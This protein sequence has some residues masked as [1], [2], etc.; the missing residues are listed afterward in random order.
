MP[1]PPV[2]ELPRT[3]E[4]RLS[5]GHAWIYR[6]HVPPGVSAPSGTWFRVRA[7]RFNG[8]GLWDASS[9]IA[10][11]I[12]SRKCVPDS[13]WI[14]GKVKAAHEL[15][16]GLRARGV[17]GYRWINGEG[18]GLPGLVVDCYGAF[19]VVATYADSVEAL[20]PGVVAA[21][22]DVR[23]PHGVV[24]LCTNA[25]A[26]SDR[27]ERLEL[28][29]GRMPPERLV[30]EEY[31][32]RLLAELRVAQK[33]GLYLDQRE[34]RH[35]LGAE[36]G[37]VRVLNLFCYTGAFSLHALRGGAASVVQVDASERA[38]AAARENF[39][40]NGVAAPEHEFVC[41][42]AFEYLKSAAG[43]G[44]RFDCVIVDPPSFARSRSQRNEA[45]HAY[46]RLFAL[47]IRVTE[48]GGVLAASSCTAQVTPAEF[49]TVLGESAARVRR[50]LQTFHEA[51]HALDHPILAGHP[52]GRYLKFVMSRVLPYD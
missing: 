14:L 21:L 47:A 41:E 11:R 37:G 17:S 43:L 4:S 13:A 25:A 15:R 29:F 18:D 36:A 3:L 48:P 2:I 28:L 30:V 32:V 6:D 52:E 51:G 1:E 46:R 16:A 22:A 7:G 39:A 27:G 34:N 45:L 42:D 33:T 12:Y 23:R 35:R 5:A 31:G 8:F 26:E 19:A 10:I 38:L 9:P 44:R 50:T 20:L 40:L 49:L 24:R